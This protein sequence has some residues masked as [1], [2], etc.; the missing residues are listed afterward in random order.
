[1][2]AI[3]A[4]LLIALATPPL[5]AQRGDTTLIFLRPLSKTSED[6][7]RAYKERTYEP[8]RI[9]EVRAA[10]FLT[11]GALMP[12]G[13][14]LGPVTPQMVPTAGNTAAMMIGSAFAVQPP[15]GGRYAIGDT[16][17]VGTS[18]PG[19]RLWG[20]AIIPTGMVRVVEVSERQTV[21]EVVTIYG[22]MRSGQVVFPAEPVA[23]PGR[24]EPV[25]TEGPSGVVL[26]SR[27]PREL[28]MPGGLLFTDLGRDDGMRLG[29]FVQ[30]R[31]RPGPRTNAADSVD[32]L[33]ATAQVVHV[34]PR[35]STIRV[36]EVISPEVQPGAP[37]VRVATLP[38]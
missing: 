24:V 30:I 15:E 25:A 28:Q 11:E 6:A 5:V 3:S 2:R 18:H 22:P 29:D 38:N 36:I 33:M 7:L 8:I 35:S 20:D 26:A 37:V 27:T 1:V 17:I 12:F 16:L 21:T 4:L 32:E 10:G 9:S 31:R 14:S 23:S 19:P 34:G 13:R